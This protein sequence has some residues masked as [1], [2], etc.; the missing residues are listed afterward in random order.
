MTRLDGLTAMVVG[1]AQGI[2][3]AT[4]VMLAARGARLV[5]ADL[6]AGQAL[7]D[8]AAEIVAGGG[9]A[10]TVTVDHT[11]EDGVRRM[12]ATAVGHFGA[13]H[14][15]VNNA[16]GTSP[17]FQANDRDI[18]TMPV[19]LWDRAMATNLRGPM[20]TCKHTI[21]HMIAA[22]YGAIVNTSSGV[23]FRGDAV[24]AAYAASK[25]GLHS[26]TMDIATAYGKQ[27]VRCNAVSPGVILTDG[28][29]AVLTS[30]QIDGIVAENLTP[31]AGTP[32]DIAEVTCFLVSPAARYVTGQVIAVDGGQHVHQNV[33]GQG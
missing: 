30:E 28:L 16:A 10:I 20:L 26:L 11:Q 1:S 7:D 3:R 14:I 18:V 5:L 6:R 2:G 13:L 29:R 32:D 8:L 9:E 31:Y 4:A 15:L 27:N 23:T 33:I 19:E 17:E 12:V 21:P 25:I 24:R 22:G